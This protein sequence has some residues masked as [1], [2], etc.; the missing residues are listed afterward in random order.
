MGMDLEIGSSQTDKAVLGLRG[1]I[2]EGRLKPGER[3]LEQTLVDMFGVSRTPARSAIQRVCDEGLVNVMPGGGYVVAS[4]TDD[5]V[6][7]AICIRGTL[8]GMAARLAAEKGISARLLAAMNECLAELDAIVS[9]SDAARF[10]S[11]YVRLNDRFHELVYEAAASPMVT[12]ALQR[13]VAIPFSVTN[14]FVEVPQSAAEAV[15]QIL[16][17][18]QQEHHR[19]VEAIGRGEGTRAEAL[20]IEHSRSAWRYL[21]LMIHHS[22]PVEG[23][24]APV[25]GAFRYRIAPGSSAK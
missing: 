20:M 18:A 15:M 23:L 9:E 24:S 17:S 16:R 12:R 13:L 4:F 5:D 25:A 22:Q 7:D 3:V 10:Q 2:V 14:S 19:I 8:E 21:N 11:D 6:F 1:L